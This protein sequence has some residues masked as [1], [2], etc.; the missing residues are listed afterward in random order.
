MPVVAH[1]A[2][3]PLPVFSCLYLGLPTS[4]EGISFS[5]FPFLETGEGEREDEEVCN[6]LKG[7]LVELLTYTEIC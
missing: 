2:E 6:S 4:A 7:I 3:A 5:G 1:S